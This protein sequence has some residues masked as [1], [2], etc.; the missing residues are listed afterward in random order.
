MAE[1]DPTVLLQL[2]I[3]CAGGVGMDAEA[4]RELAGAGQALAGKHLASEDGEDNLGDQLLAERNFGA[5]IE[6]ETHV[7]LNLP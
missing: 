3:G 4:A 2:A 7:S 6:P 1:L 5:A